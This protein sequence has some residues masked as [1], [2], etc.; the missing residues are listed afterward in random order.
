M[1]RALSSTLLITDSAA[2][3][4]GRV[5]EARIR[6]L[7]VGKV[8]LA[9]FCWQ[10]WGRDAGGVIEWN[11]FAG[12]ALGASSDNICPLCKV[13]GKRPSSSPC[14]ARGPH[15][16]AWIRNWAVLVSGSLGIVS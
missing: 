12:R 9:K 13:Q 8:H 3:I 6:G 10:N 11:V 7:A 5:F 1:G 14:G 15:T 16:Q 2:E 4:V